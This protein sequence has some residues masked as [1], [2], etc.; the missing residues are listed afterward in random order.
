[1]I[2]W[3]V[4]GS[5]IIIFLLLLG[6]S[7]FFRWLVFKEI[8]L[9]TAE[10]LLISIVQVLYLTFEWAYPLIIN[11]Q[12]I[13]SSD[14]IYVLPLIAI[15]IMFSVYIK[16]YIGKLEKYKDA[17]IDIVFDKIPNN[18][19]IKKETQLNNI[20][21]IA[22]KIIPIDVLGILP[23]KKILRQKV[24]DLINDLGASHLTEDEFRIKNKGASWIMLSIIFISI[25]CVLSASLLT[26]VNAAKRNKEAAITNKT[27]SEEKINNKGGK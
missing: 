20:K 5:G 4:F 2:D 7:F 9:P 26:G 19:K 22:Y 21:F 10:I 18:I 1:M 17:Q 6:I 13:D 25:L 24:I 23:G 16:L 15:F 11:P 8:E 27:M 14:L 12:K 3:A